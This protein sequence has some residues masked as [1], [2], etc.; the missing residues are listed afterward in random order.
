VV[1]FYIDHQH[2][3]QA[4][5]LLSAIAV[6]AGLFFFTLLR[7]FVRR[8]ERARPYSTVALAGAIVFAAGCGLSAG[9][10]LALADVPGQL[11]PGAAQT[12]N[13]LNN[14]L[15]A[16][17]MIGGLA[18]M[19]LGFGAAFLLGRALPAWLGWVTVAIGV[20]S[21]AGPFAFFGLL[22]T[23]VWVLV[24]SGMIHPKLKNEYRAPAI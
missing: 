20:I 15:V 4:S 16:G 8:S 3:T 13:I 11:T 19:Q 17:L 14:D 6:V 18:T 9:L 12:L 1:R 5:A 22:G 23:A 21:L 7:E 24:V 2:Q 10:S